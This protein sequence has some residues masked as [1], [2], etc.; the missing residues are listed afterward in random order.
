MAYFVVTLSENAHA[1]LGE[2]DELVLSFGV[3][4]P[5]S[6]VAR[7]EIDRELQKTFVLIVAHDR[8]SFESVEEG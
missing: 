8:G 6:T 1:I 2:D 3:F 7:E 5:Q 4:A